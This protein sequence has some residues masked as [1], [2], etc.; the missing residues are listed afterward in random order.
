MALEALLWDVDGTLAETE[1][2]GHRRAFNLAFAEAGLPIHWDAETYGHWLQISGGAERI[3]AALADLEGKQPSAER[4]A[5]L[6]VRKQLHYGTLMATGGLHLR[7]GVAAMLAAA[8][9]AGMPQVIVTTS[10]RSAV[11]SLVKHLLPSQENVFSFWVCGDDVARKKPD[12]EAYCQA[13][14]AL[15]IPAGRLLA[16]E[17]S[18]AGLAAASAA[19][20]ACVITRSHYGAREPMD[21][22]ATAR[23]VLTGLGPGDGV[24]SGPPCPQ[25]PITLAYLRSLL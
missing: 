14:E 19:E 16:L 3:R 2:D 24:I 5:S 1:R 4:V 22:F 9:A 25:G 17:D 15:G 8:Q 11:E 12:P 21:R 10:G 23:A 20:V 18:G 7:P 6:Q 13:A